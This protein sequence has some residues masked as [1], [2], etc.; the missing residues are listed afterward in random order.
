MTSAVWS[1]RRPRTDAGTL[2][3]TITRHGR[4]TSA[5]YAA[6]ETPALPDEA[7]AIPRAPISTA[8]ART[9]GEALSLWLPVGFIHS[10]L[11]R[12]RPTGAEGVKSSS[13]VPPSPRPLH[14]TEGSHSPISDI[15]APRSGSWL[16]Y[17]L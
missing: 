1:A 2:A 4:P 13:G 16:G 11:S 14:R 9:S 3:V 10:A 15:F 5:A 12:S 6:I 8:R 17:C 7:Q